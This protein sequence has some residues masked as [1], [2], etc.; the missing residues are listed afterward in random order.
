MKE[1]LFSFTILFVVLSGCGRDETPRADPF[2]V[3]GVVSNTEF[4]SPKSLTQLRNDQTKLTSEILARLPAPDAASLRAALTSTNG[5][6]VARGLEQ[7]LFAM[8]EEETTRMGI[9]KNGTGTN[10]L[11]CLVTYRADDSNSDAHVA[12]TLATNKIERFGIQNLGIFYWF[13][14]RNKFIVSK[15]LLKAGKVDHNYYTWE[16]LP[17]GKADEK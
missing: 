4:N 17:N 10:A 2:V 1:S 13:V 7:L 9:S 8:R 16:Y 14:P 12:R 3:S 15:M 11:W 5:E 6:V